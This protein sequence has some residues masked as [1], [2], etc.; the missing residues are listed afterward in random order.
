M[1]IKIKEKNPSG[2]NSIRAVAARLAKGSQ[3]SDDVSDVFREITPYVKSV[4]KYTFSNANPSQWDAI[5]DKYIAWKT[6]HGYPATI[7]IMTGAMK[8]AVSDSAKIEI[9][10]LKFVYSI[11]TSQ[12]NPRG[13]TVGSYAY[14]FN[15]KRNIMD[16]AK[17]RIR[18]TIKQAVKKSI[19]DGFKNV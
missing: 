17:I 16:Y 10:R 7:G 9:G 12:A 5:S 2:R 6:K 15:K 3:R 1:P 14:Y 19:A 11:N 13:G 18:G 4:L 8:E